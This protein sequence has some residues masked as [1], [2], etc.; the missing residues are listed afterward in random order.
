M[1]PKP[2]IIQLSESPSST[3]DWGGPS[4]QGTCTTDHAGRL[5]M[6]SAS[7]RG[8][9]LEFI[10]SWPVLTPLQVRLDAGERVEVDVEDWQV[11]AV[12]S[13]T[14]GGAGARGDGGAGRVAGLRLILVGV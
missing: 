2:T 9:R 10:G 7:T 8:H 13:R 1:E 5:A 14:A 4:I 11:V 3:G 12:G 6:A